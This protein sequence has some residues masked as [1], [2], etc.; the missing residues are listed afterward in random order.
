MGTQRNYHYWNWQKN[1]SQ[2]NA[3]IDS[4]FRAMASVGTQR[5]TEAF[6]HTPAAWHRTQLESQQKK[7][8]RTKLKSRRRKQKNCW[9]HLLDV[10]R[11]IRQHWP[12]QCRRRSRWVAVCH[13][14]RPIDRRPGIH[15]PTRISLCG[16]SDLLVN[17]MLDLCPSLPTVSAV[18]PVWTQPNCCVHR[19]PCWISLFLSFLFLFFSVTFLQCCVSPYL[20]HTH[21][22]SSF[23]FFFQTPATSLSAPI[24]FRCFISG[25]FDDHNKDK[26]KKKNVKLGVKEICWP[27]LRSRENGSLLFARTRVCFAVC[28]HNSRDDQCKVN[29]K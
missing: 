27:N 8:S 11:L 20:S 9:E 4:Q 10:V 16:C 18:R 24:S 2:P 21:T 7:K 12:Y 3:Y 25:A 28:L 1:K 23:S 19:M 6:L 26:K 13:L 29:R 14:C 15:S 5:Q 17:S 22:N